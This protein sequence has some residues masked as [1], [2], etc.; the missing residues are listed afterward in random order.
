MTNKEILEK[1]I[2]KAIDGGWTGDLADKV[3]SCADEDI[4]LLIEGWRNIHHLEPVN[5]IFDHNFAKAIWG[6]K[7][8]EIAQS[9]KHLKLK[10]KF[11]RSVP[12]H[13]GW[14]YHLQN[15]VIANDPIK[16]IGANL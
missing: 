1:A 15:M 8:V 13:E 16:Y 6:D 14:Q 9:T 11:T 3:K 10:G 2:Q 4:E 12:G 5:F 7:Q